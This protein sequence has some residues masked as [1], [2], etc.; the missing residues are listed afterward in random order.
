MHRRLRS[1]LTLLGITIGLMALI[2]LIAV[3]QGMSLAVT[4]HF[5]E[6]G[7]DHILITRGRTG[8]LSPQFVPPSVNLSRK[9]LRAIREVEGVDL[10]AGVLG[11]YMKLRFKNEIKYVLLWGTPTDSESSKLI[12]KMSFF[13]LEEGRFLKD[14]DKYKVILGA[15]IA[16]DFFSKKVKNGD[17]VA[18]NSYEFDVVGIQKK[19][20]T[21]HDYIARIPLETAREIFNEPESVTA[22]MVIVKPNIEPAELIDDIEKKLRD[23]RGIKEGEED[24]SVQTTEKVVE[25][26][27]NIVISIRYVLAGIAIIAIVVG[28]IGIMNTMYTAM[29]ERTHDI[30]IMKA[31]GAKRYDIT[32][33]FLI[34]SGMLGLIGG[35]MG[36]IL[37]VFLSRL[38]EYFA[39]KFGAVALKFTI[40]PQLA[41]G[42][43]AFSLIIGLISGVSPARRAA[44]LP[45]VEALR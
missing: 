1:F 42:M 7:A 13:D 39:V 43:L 23:T 38:I 5:K 28:G 9:D 21:F 19:A 34:E 36:I 10:A 32:L 17:R 14:E 15:D 35:V 18:I 4:E 24:F 25:S 8:P 33:L 37:S 2:T 11:K 40:N 12:Q 27:Q 30:G 6:L 22:I 29:L 44:N 45:P 26:F 3:G 20:G 41:L 31:V 16:Y